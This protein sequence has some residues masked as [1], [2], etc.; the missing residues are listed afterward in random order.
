M[1][2]GIGRFRRDG[3]DIIWAGIG[4]SRDLSALHAKLSENLA[5]AGFVLEGRSYKPHLTLAREV[6]LRTGFDLAGFSQSTVEIRT[7][8][9]HISLM[10]SERLN[11]KLIYTDITER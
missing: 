8:V 3:G 6:K 1:I 7:L 9:S 4:L 5:A 10:K 2:K 11:G